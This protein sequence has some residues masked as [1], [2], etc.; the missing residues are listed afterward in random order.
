MSK[1]V[2]VSVSSFTLLFVFFLHFLYLLD[3]I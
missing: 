2:T 1:K 3:N